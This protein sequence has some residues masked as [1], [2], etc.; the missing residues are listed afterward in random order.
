MAKKAKKEE[1][2]CE[3]L[4]ELPSFFALAFFFVYFYT[5]PVARSLYR[6]LSPAVA[7]MQFV[8]QLLLVGSLAFYVFY[9][10]FLVSHTL[11][12]PPCFSSVLVR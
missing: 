8:Q 3:V 1:G 7:R 6:F 12:P 5:C 4:V 9:L 10:G 2:A 11:P